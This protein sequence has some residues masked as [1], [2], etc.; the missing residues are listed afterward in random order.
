M[1]PHLAN[2]AEV[3]P[4]GFITLFIRK[5][6]RYDANLSTF[7]SVAQLRSISQ[8]SKYSTSS[9]VFL[10]HTKSFCIFISSNDNTTNI[11]KGLK[12]LVIFKLTHNFIIKTSLWCYVMYVIPQCS[13]G[14]KYKHSI[15]IFIQQQLLV[16]CW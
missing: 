10:S 5:T 4:S 3:Y 13:L 9:P 2:V 15:F 11:C 6:I 1:L 8:K 16:S 12:F 14:W 7:G